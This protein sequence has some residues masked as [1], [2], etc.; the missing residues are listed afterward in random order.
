MRNQNVVPSFAG[1]IH[2]D[3]HAALGPIPR[4]SSGNALVLSEWG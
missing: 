4:D 1:N 2:T 3:N